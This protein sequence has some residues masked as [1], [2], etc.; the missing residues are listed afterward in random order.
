MRTSLFAASLVL[1]CLL[2]IPSQTFAD[3]TETLGPPGIRIAQG[4]GFV[5]AGTGLYNGSGTIQ[6]D[7]PLNAEIRQAILYWEGQHRN[8]N[9][10][11][12]NLVVNGQ[13][14][15]G[16][17]IG[18]PTLFETRGTEGPDVNATAFR[19]DITGYGFIKPGSNTLQVSGSTFDF[20][21]DGAG[22]LVIY[23]ESSGLRDIQVRD[24]VDIAYKNFPSP[25]DKT[26]PQTF[27][28]APASTPRTA[29]LSLFVGSV[30]DS[31]PRPNKR[32]NAIRIIIGSAHS[33]A[34]VQTVPLGKMV[35]L[36]TPLLTPVLEDFAPICYLAGLAAGKP[37][38]TH[39]ALSTSETL[40]I[41]QLDSKD[42]S[43][44]DTFRTQ[45]EIPAEASELTVEI[46]SYDDGSGN[47]PASLTWVTA[48]FAITEAPPP[49]GEVRKG[50]MTGGGSVFTADGNR[51]THG[52]R[53][54]CDPS[55]QPNNLEVNWGQGNKFH[56]EQ[57]TSASCSDDPAIGPAPPPA[58]F[59]THKG[60]GNGNY[61]GVPGATVEWTFTDAGEPG[62]NDRARMV[63]RDPLGNVVLS[64]DGKLNK[65]NHQA[66]SGGQGGAKA[67]AVP[68]AYRVSHNYPNPFNPS[69]QIEYQLPAAGKVSLVV[70][71]ALGQQIRVLAQGYHQIG[72]YTATWDGM[73]ERGQ[74][75]SGGVYFYRFSSEGLVETRRM[76]LLK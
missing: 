29:D 36:G 28:F 11:D 20:A 38:A 1:G 56:L 53:V 61:N 74:S 13:T 44:W 58:G 47:R 42:G 49:P 8:T 68:A 12:P 73:D 45:V 35:S 64:V 60:A 43:E 65:G 57:M 24:G 30:N 41:N 37:V 34:T 5:E 72:R 21:N 40:L 50:W 16:E 19:T 7:V 62:T 18:G 69:T 55:Q 14:V 32:P 27:V 9:T 59:D 75:V 17:R 23:A 2:L 3:G 15:W 71:N 25:R 39:N 46:L 4:T 54:N 33:E 22:V 52:F 10:G 51:V 67:T 66:H 70:Y 26:V 6:V 31:L 48:I 63:I 76:L